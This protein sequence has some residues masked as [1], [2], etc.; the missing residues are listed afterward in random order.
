MGKTK[1][2][3]IAVISVGNLAMG[4][5]GKTPHTI[6]ITNEYLKRGE[7]TAVLSL[8]YKGGIGYGVNVISDGKN[9]LHSPP[10]AADEPYMIGINC[11]G[12]VVITGKCR[13]EAAILARDEF[14][15]HIA[16]LDDGFQYGKLER[17]ANILLL[18]WK[19]PFSTG[20]PFPFGYLREFPSACRRADIII[21]TRADNELIPEKAK[22][23]TEDKPIFFSKPITDKIVLNKDVFTRGELK[24][25]KAAAFSAVASNKAFLKALEALELEVV[26]FKGFRD[27]AFLNEE[28]VEKIIGEGTKN[29]AELFITT[30]KDFVKLNKTYRNIFGYLK[31]EIE[32]NNRPIFFKMLSGLIYK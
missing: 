28:T 5:A 4:G 9:I 24:N 23:Y 30:E 18:D 22:K 7:K 26:Y 32:M 27:H 17:D 29:G 19:K 6:A 21:F 31:M 2:N 13:H 14:G 20:F 12:A 8:G 15:C 11:P 16:V 25:K 1:N 10:Q 3:G